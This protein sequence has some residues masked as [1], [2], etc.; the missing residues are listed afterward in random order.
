MAKHPSRVKILSKHYDDIKSLG[1]EGSFL[2]SNNLKALEFK[3]DIVTSVEDVS[4]FRF[5]C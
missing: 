1:I 5:N 4:M 2:S 3:D